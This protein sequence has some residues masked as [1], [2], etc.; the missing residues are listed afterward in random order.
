MRVKTSSKKHN[1]KNKYKYTIQKMKRRIIYSI[2]LATVLT[3]CG[4]QKQNAAATKPS[5]KLLTIEQQDATTV[6]NYS[7]SIRGKQDIEIYPQVSGYLSQI[8]VNEGAQ[9]KKGQVLFIIDQAPYLA[10]LQSAKAGVVVAEANVASAQLTYDNSVELK[11]RNIISEAELLNIQIKLK[12][13]KAQLALAKS[14]ETSAQV[15]FDFTVIKSPAD[16]VVGKFPYRQGTLVSPGM[17]ESLTVVSN[18]SKMYVYFSL[19]EN[20]V[21][22]LIDEYGSL[23]NVADAMG[24]VELMLSNGSIYSEKGKIESI[25]GIIEQGTGAVS[26]RAVFPN[27]ERKLLSGSAGSVIVT[28]HFSD[29]IVLPKVATFELQDKVLVYKVV[30]NKAKSTLVEVAKG[31][32]DKEFIVIG[33]LNPGDEII[34]EGAGLVRE[35]TIVK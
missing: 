16:G 19:N 26:V 7:A 10:A 8:K 18:N 4:K 20:Q 29:K 12:G 5:Y 13:A 6:T 1:T 21:L 35:G 27:T 23:D 22:D 32:T 33:G 15:N 14:Q 31:S 2:L 30:D 24:E 34:A 9:V 3:G 25:S 17:R 11:E 28:Q